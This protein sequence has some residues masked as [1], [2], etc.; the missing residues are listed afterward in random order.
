MYCIQR[1]PY[2]IEHVQNKKCM[3][4]KQGSAQA[5]CY[6]CSL[7]FLSTL[8]YHVW[9]CVWVFVCVWVCV[10]F[11]HENCNPLPTNDAPMC[12][13]LSISLWE[14]LYGGFNTT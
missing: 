3:Q 9:V 11:V 1:S 8:G 6:F 5:V 10:L 4:C 2:S 14:F 13:G 12:H 7:V